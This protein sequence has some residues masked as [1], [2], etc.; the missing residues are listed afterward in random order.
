MKTL[1]R[2]WI[3][4]FCVCLVFSFCNKDEKIVP[5]LQVDK[6]SIEATAEAGTAFLDITSNVDW[7]F[8]GIPSWLT[9]EPS[10]GRGNAQVEFSYPANVKADQLTVTLILN[11][12]G[13]ASGRV[14]FNQIGAA[15]SMLIN[16]TEIEEKPEGQL[17]S[18]TITS[19]VPWKIV[20]PLDSWWIT[21]G[22]ST[23]KAGVTKLYFT[24]APNNR[25]GSREAVIKLESTGQAVTPLSLKI[26]QAQPEIN[27]SSFTPN[28]KGGATIKIQGTGFSSMLNENSVTINGQ[29][30]VVTKAA[31][32]ELEVTVPVA[33]GTGKI[34]VTV[35]TKTGVSS[36]DF[37]YDLVWRVYTVPV[38]ASDNDL[39]TPAAVVIGS[40]GFLYVADKTAQQIKKISPT[41]IVSILA[42]TGDKGFQDGPGNTAMFDDPSALAIDGN[43][44]LYVS[45]RNNKRIRKIEP[46]G[47]VS[48]LAGDGTTAAFN[49]PQ[50]ITVGADG[51]VYVADYGNHRIRR[52]TPAGVV[53][54]IAGTG[55]AGSTD[56]MGTAASFNNPAAIEITTDGTIY[57]AESTARRI[58]KID[59]TGKVTTLVNGL[60][61]DPFTNPSDIAS[62]AAGNIYVVDQLRHTVYSLSTGGMATAIAG[63]VLPGHKD[64]EG[65]AAKFNLPVA[66]ALGA[67]G[68]LLVADQGNKMIRKLFKQ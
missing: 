16:K 24:I 42:G 30:A 44:N 67:N 60:T 66:I 21:P 32:D 58:R 15:P 31:P 3:L 25:I 51:N 1:F 4:F 8:S 64:G 14:V 48:T 20:M 18:V 55:T 43:N 45:D 35:G 54:T 56:G 65:I 38:I 2:E 10:S 63:A 50:G 57:V 41:G 47:N 26:T 22:A 11:G 23:G 33:A 19:N 59:N 27:I 29:N 46:N 36:T 62:D 52:I 5:V 9:I 28:G 49:N 37:L 13:L 61:N 34:A 40:D 6:S 53:T 17:D 39:S 7:D 68:E 12:K